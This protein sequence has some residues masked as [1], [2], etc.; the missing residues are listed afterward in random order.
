MNQHEDDPTK[1]SRR[2]L[3]RLAS[4]T[5]LAAGLAQ[6]QRPAGDT[7]YGVKFQAKDTVRMGFIGLGGRGTSLLRN[8]AAV[9]RETT[10]IGVRYAELHRT[11]LARRIVQVDTRY[12]RIPVKVALDGDTVLN[13]APEYEACAAAARAHGVPVKAVFAAALVAYEARSAVD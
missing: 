3:L 12:G 10:T 4:L 6:A 11:V 8:Y 9:L 1:S 2:D 5:P 7:M 13:S